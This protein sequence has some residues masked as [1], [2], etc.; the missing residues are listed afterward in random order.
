M[1]NAEDARR[2]GTMTHS[3][4]AWRPVSFR[5]TT[6]CV[7]ILLCYYVDCGNRFTFPLHHRLLLA[8]K[9]GARARAL[10]PGE[11]ATM[12]E[13]N[14][15]GREIAPTSRTIQA[16]LAIPETAIRVIAAPPDTLTQRNVEAVTGLSPRV[17]L[18]AI[19]TPT[20]PLRVTKLGKLRIVNRAS[21][22][23]WLE[24]REL[25]SVAGRV[26]ADEQRTN[27]VEG[28]LK[29]VGLERCRELAKRRN[30]RGHR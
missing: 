27:P 1:T 7:T 6:A 5:P 18:E 3:R 28:I 8:A 11:D 17:Y 22:V 9:S 14:D 19:R 10:G 25:V 2:I 16:T 23:E 20:F 26:D 13:M 12:K 15:G 21:F 30:G 24:Q 29:T 4:H